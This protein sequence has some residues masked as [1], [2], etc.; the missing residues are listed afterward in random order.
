MVDADGATQFDELAKL[1][2]AQRKFAHADVGIVCGSRAHLQ[3]E[4]VAQ[5]SALRNLL[6]YGF[7]VLVVL[8][9]GI[10]SVRDTQCGFKLFARRTAAQTFG[11]LHVERWI[12]DL[13]LLFLALKYFDAPVA[14]VPVRWHEVGA[15]LFGAVLV[16]IHGLLVA[17]G[18]KLSVVSASLEMARDLLRIRLCYMLGLWSV[19]DR[20]N[21]APNQ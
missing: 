2:A 15:C 12:F 20:D 14:E 19:H 13:E 3:D 17:D 18:S 8:V 6:M 7:H 21:D 16:F 4:A 5:R 10:S 11:C 1:E 9:G